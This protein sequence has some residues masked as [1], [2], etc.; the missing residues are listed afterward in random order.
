MVIFA[1][2]QERFM[3]HLIDV[4]FLSF[5]VYLMIT[6]LTFYDYNRAIIFKELSYLILSAA[7]YVYFTSSNWQ[8]T[9]GKK[10]LGIK[11]VNQNM[12]KLSLR[13]SFKRYIG[14]YFSYI[15]AGL[16]FL[17]LFTNQQNQALQDKIAKTYVISTKREKND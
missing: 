14:Y 6:I 15:S 13:N 12:E 16:G 7:Y 1:K 4:A 3:A 8:A 2:A 10:I 17:F 9:I 11:V 5:I